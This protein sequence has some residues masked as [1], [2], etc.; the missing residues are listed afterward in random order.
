MSALSVA[1]VWFFKYFST[2]LSVCLSSTDQTINSGY[3]FV[4]SSTNV[5]DYVTKN[6]KSSSPEPPRIETEKMMRNTCGFTLVGNQNQ[7]TKTITHVGGTREQE[8]KTLQ[9]LGLYLPSVSL[10]PLARLLCTVTLP[11]YLGLC[12]Q[13]TACITK[14]PPSPP[15]LLPSTYRHCS[16]STAVNLKVLWNAG[17][18]IGLPSSAAITSES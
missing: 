18:R 4:E 12:A 14:P 15:P 3:R 7:K 1:L 5:H 13:P 16:S 9:H 2:C 8:K 10:L 11:V 17:R 6:I